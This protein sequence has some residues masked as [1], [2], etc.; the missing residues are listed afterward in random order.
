VKI[1]ALSAEGVRGD[2]R[3]GLKAV[4]AHGTTQLDLAQRRHDTL[5]RLPFLKRGNFCAM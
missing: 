5:I 1:R 3:L 4:S 2:H